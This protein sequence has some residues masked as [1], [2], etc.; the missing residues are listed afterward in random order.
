MRGF[1]YP[2]PFS[3]EMRRLVKI[4]RKDILP[5]LDGDLLA[6][7]ELAAEC[8]LPAGRSLPFSK[9]RTKAKQRKAALSVLYDAFDWPKAD[10]NVLG[11]LYES[12]L[13]FGRSAAV[14]AAVPR[15]SPPA[16]GRMP[17]VLPA[18]CRR[19]GIAKK[20]GQRRK[21]GVFYTPGYITRF[22]V[23]AAVNAC[24]PKLK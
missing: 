7:I 23:R 19:Y 17:A 5:L 22:L 10:A 14:P 24:L 4:C 11:V 12:L 20:Q 2:L 3:L 13:D 6:L 1:L 18:R 21:A 9:R 15:A 8:L 16:A